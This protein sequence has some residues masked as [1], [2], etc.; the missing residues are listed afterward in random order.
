MILKIN[1][2]AVLCFLGFA[3][4]AEQIGDIRFNAKIISADQK[5]VQ[6]ETGGQKFE[7]PRAA[8]PTGKLEVGQER[9]I[10]SSKVDYQQMKAQA[11][12]R[13]SSKAAPKAKK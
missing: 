4:N 5:L 12:Y 2:L 13:E 8:L 3:A 7:L 10:A 6:I 9:E 1:I 11:M